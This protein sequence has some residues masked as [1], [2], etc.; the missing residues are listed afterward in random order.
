MKIIRTIELY[1]ELYSTLKSP[2]GLVP[3]LGGIHEGHLSLVDIAKL[4]CATV[5][6]WLFLNPKQF[7]LDEDLD[8]YPAEEKEDI[9]LLDQRGVD[10]LVIPKITDIYPNDFDTVVRLE[11]ITKLL[12]G[13]RRP[14][15]F[16]GVTTIV[17]KMFNIIQPNRAY[18]GEKDAQQLRVVQKMVKD[19]NFPIEIIPCPTVR[20][21][22]GLALSSRNKYLST[23]ERHDVVLLYQGL[24][25][26]KISFENGENDSDI[27]RSIVIQE[28]E[29]S[30]LISIDYISVSDHLSLIEITGKIETPVLLSLA[31]HVGKTHL[32]DNMLLQ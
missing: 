25:K 16:D 11:K 2:I 31:V 13:S 4:E 8:V 22:D 27:I 30:S 5:V 24:C 3:T 10:I 20:D 29:K 15:H 9:A 23:A 12:E 7:A 17:S 18:F 6:S 19:L 21:N 26:A 32:I 1:R 14:G 28:I